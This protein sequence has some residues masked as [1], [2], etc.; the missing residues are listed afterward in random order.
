MTPALPARRLLQDRAYEEIKALIQ[1]GSLPSGS[2]LSERALARRLRMSTTPVR[3]ALGRL[4][5]EGFVSISPQQGIVVREPSIQE[6]VDLFDLRE[7]LESFVARRLAGRLSPE[8]ARLLRENL[9]R[10]EEAAR[11]GDTL[12]LTHLDAEFHLLL[13]RFHGNR[14]IE[15]TLW[16]LRDKLHRVILRV[17][18]RLPGRPREAVREHAAIADAVLRGQPDRAAER[19]VRHLEFGRK[20]LVSR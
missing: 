18:S 20:F 7:A 12:G 10:Q 14:E 8:Q 2:F 15:Q 16:R 11:A 13:C 19:I 5:H 3:L 9:R 1:N 17:M 4:A 6:I